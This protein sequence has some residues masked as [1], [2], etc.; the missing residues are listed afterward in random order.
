LQDTEAL[1]SVTLALP[2]G[3]H[4]TRALSFETSESVTSDTL[5]IPPAMLTRPRS[6]TQ[7]QGA[8]RPT[9]EMLE[10]SKLRKP[11]IFVVDP[12]ASNGSQTESD[13]VGVTIPV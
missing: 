13:D 7:P 2:P 3:R 1:N 12:T 5:S 10:V 8:I 6:S 4:L 9:R 11:Q